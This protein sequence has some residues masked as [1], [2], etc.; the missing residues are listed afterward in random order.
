MAAVDQSPIA[1]NPA[2]VADAA[3]PA[4]LAG[5][6]R[7][8][9]LIHQGPLSRVYQAQP[10]GSD[11]NSP[12]SYAVKLLAPD[13]EQNEA[14]VRIFEREAVVGTTVSNPH[15]VPVLASQLAHPPRYLVMPWL[16][17][18][19]LG[20]RLAQGR[21]PGLAA[22]LWYA[23]QAAEALAALDAAGWMHGDI[24]PANLLVSAEG[25][26][27]L[28]DLGFARR[29]GESA[30]GLDRVLLGTPGY[31]P[32]EAL[33]RQATSDIRGD[34]YSLG[35][36]LCEMLIGRLPG[37]GDDP[38]ELQVVLRQKAARKVKACHPLAP[39]A[40]V[41]LLE[42]MLSGQPLRRPQTPAELIEQLVP[43]EIKTLGMR[44][45]A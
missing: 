10:V 7:L 25:H 18:Q 24:K 6:W 4:V 31:L 15:L 30:S 32:P 22:A 37:Q 28:I 2:A 35:V 17:A 41:R 42:Q 21:G 38:L 12:P 40:L 45:V 1:T 33:S 19:N 5:A 13:W 8:L 3:Q 23:R 36:T 27:T 9:R 39:R 11:P 43:L 44:T 26:V 29:R 20:A 34:I 14:A 16:R